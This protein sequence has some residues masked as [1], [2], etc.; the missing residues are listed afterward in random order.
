[1]ALSVSEAQLRVLLE[2][3]SFIRA[4]GFELHSIAESEATLSIPFQTS[5]LRPGNIIA[6]PFLWRPPTSRCGSR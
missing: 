1:M 2:E 3:T 5:F 4:Y 6:G